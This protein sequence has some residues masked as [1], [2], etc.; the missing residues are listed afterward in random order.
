MGIR[1]ANKSRE[2]LSIDDHELIAEGLAKVLASRDCGLLVTI[3]NNEVAALDN[4]VESSIQTS[5]KAIYHV[6]LVDSD[7]PDMSGVDFTKSLRSRRVQ[8]PPIVISVTTDLRE[9]Q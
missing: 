3:S 2:I 6:I 7:L 9:V 8:I 4:I 5:Q 1:S